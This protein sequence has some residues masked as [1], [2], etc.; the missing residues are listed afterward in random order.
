[1]LGRF[2]TVFLVW[3]DRGVEPNTEGPALCAIAGKLTNT[4]WGGGS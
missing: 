3:H 4:P 1:V 2:V